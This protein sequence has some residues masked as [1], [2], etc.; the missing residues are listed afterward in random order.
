MQDLLEPNTYTVFMVPNTVT[1]TSSPIYSVSSI[2][3][4]S[5]NISN[6]FFLSIHHYSSGSYSILSLLVLVE[7]RALN[8]LSIILLGRD[9]FPSR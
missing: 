6:S 4:V 1:V 9:D 8:F 5:I 2:L 7:R 3:L